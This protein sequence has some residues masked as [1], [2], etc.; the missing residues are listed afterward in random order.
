M[1]DGT[2]AFYSQCYHILTYLSNQRTCT[3]CTIWY[4]GKTKQLSTTQ[5]R[6]H[7]S[8]VIDEVRYH[9]EVFAVGR[10]DKLEAIIL[11]YPE[12]TNQKLNELTNFNA[13][14]S[15]FDFLEDEPDIYSRNDLKNICF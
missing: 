5:I 13:N 9:G 11:K 10:R 6:N 4:Y 8:E 1:G 3:K 2:P 15:S 7:I 14:S 12:Y